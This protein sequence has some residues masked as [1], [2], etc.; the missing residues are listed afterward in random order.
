MVE[1]FPRY[2]AEAIERA[3]AEEAARKSDSP[4]RVS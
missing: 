3:A 1:L 2:G 4:A